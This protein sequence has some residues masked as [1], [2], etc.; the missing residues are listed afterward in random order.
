VALWKSVMFERMCRMS[1][2]LS[3]RP[4]RREVPAAARPAIK[5]ELEANVPAAFWEGAVRQ[6]LA[7]EPDVLG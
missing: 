5:R 6:L 7:R 2:E 4:D 3:A 1:F